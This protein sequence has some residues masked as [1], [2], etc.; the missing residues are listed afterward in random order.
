MVIFITVNFYLDHIHNMN[1]DHIHII[2]VKKLTF[3]IGSGG[4][5]VEERNNKLPIIL[6]V[7]A[8]VAFLLIACVFVTILANRRRK[9]RLQALAMPTSTGIH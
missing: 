9:A 5:I 6:G 7:V 1:L 8:A 2:Y 4:S 3:V